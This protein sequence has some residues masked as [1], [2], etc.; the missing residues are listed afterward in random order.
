LKNADIK[1]GLDS[2]ERELDTAMN[3]FQ[4]NSNIVLQSGQRDVINTMKSNT[5]ELRDLLIQALTVKSETQ[6]IVEMQNAGERV[7]EIFME[8]GQRELLHLRQSLKNDA[9]ATSNSPLPQPHDSF[10]YL[11]Y[12]R[13]L[14]NLRRETGIPP[15]IKILDGEVTKVGEL[16]VAGGTYSD[17]WVGMWL[18]E[19]KV[20]LKCLRNV[21]A[22]DP[23]AKKRF[24]NEMNLWADLK[25]KHIVPFHGIVT[26]LG[27]QI[28]MVSPWQTNGDVLEYALRIALKPILS[29]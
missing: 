8:A 13:G 10:R 12:Q 27:W 17:I 2:C 5:A 9:G 15:T 28:H 7:A 25:N 24:E 11:Q 18:G 3:L 19:E 20:A 21:K 1:D 4:I 6:Q 26:D 14:I 29:I 23:K 16:A 22:S